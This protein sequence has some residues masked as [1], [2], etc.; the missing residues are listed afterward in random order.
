M[1]NYGPNIFGMPTFT[2]N[3]MFRCLPEQARVCYH[4]DVFVFSFGERCR[5]P[6]PSQ[7]LGAAPS[8]E[9]NGTRQDSDVT[10]GSTHHADISAA[11]PLDRV[12]RRPRRICG[13]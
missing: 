10:N 12:V 3:D 7:K 6:Q 9:A 11:K 1:R 4:L 2:L 13:R 8:I 5:A